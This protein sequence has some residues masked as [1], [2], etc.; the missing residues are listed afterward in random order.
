MMTCY[1]HIATCPATGAQWS[2]SKSY[3]QVCELHASLVA[4]TENLPDDHP[5]S[6]LLHRAIVAL[7]LYDVLHEAADTA[8]GRRQRN[9]AMQALLTILMYVRVVVDGYCHAQAAAPDTVTMYDSTSFVQTKYVVDAF[10][11]TIQR[12]RS[13]NNYIDDA[14]PC[15]FIPPKPSS[16]PPV[17]IVSSL[18]QLV[19][20]IEIDDSR[21]GYLAWMLHQFVLATSSAFDMEGHCR[22][23]SECH[24]WIV[25][26]RW[27]VHISGGHCV[28]L[29]GAANPALYQALRHVGNLLD[30]WSGPSVA[31]DDEDEAC[32][33]C[34]EPMDHPDQVDILECFHQFHSTCMEEWVQQRKICPICCRALNRPGPPGRLEQLPGRIPLRHLQDRRRPWRFWEA[35]AVISV[36]TTLS[37]ITSFYFSPV[38]LELVDPTLY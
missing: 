6:W 2:V 10:L 18:Q 21:L 8:T 35:C 30:D 20:H 16:N 31:G 23:N 4:A 34:W 33:I 37:F 9:A 5:L 14:T 1:E 17:S 26:L 28:D 11:S 32:A 38:L 24:K 3:T 12:R 7:P 13:T 27:L 22:I 25:Q 36:A 15:P 19:A 29:D